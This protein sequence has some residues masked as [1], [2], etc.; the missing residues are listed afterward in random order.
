MT[1]SWIACRA[2]SYRP[3]EKQAYKH[4]AE[5]GIHCLE[6]SVP[7]PNKIAQVQNNLERFGL[8]A[9]SLQGNCDVRQPD[10]A[11][12]IAAQM[13][14]FA[15]LQSRY[16]FVSVKADKTP[17]E[18]VYDRL[19][20]AGDEAAR[21]GVTIVLETHPDLVTNAG[22]AL[23][24]IQAVNHPRIR[25]NFDTANIYFYNRDIEAAAELRQIA[26]YVAAVHLKDTDGGFMHWHFPA[27]G[28]G[29]VNFR[30]IFAI[31]DEVG[32]TGPC[33][34]EIEG[35]E[36]ET[37]TERLVC[38]RIAESLGYLRGLGRV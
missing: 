8:T 27:L 3:F 13:P 32:F 23:Q 35:L 24:T 5:L 7:P 4:L 31:L 17:L 15:A 21:H 10:I 11:E 38:D 28:R 36:G 26:P 1:A 29:I 6:I 14:A 12:Q 33:T 22:V 25:V 34:L 18:I 19:R 16:M 20:Q 9:S 2:S 30:E 37:K